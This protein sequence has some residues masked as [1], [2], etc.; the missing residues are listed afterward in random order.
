MPDCKDFQRR[1][2]LFLDGE[3]DGRA[4]RELALHASR[5][6]SCEEE[7]R[8]CEGVQTVLAAAV[9]AELQRVDPAA[10]WTG[11]RGRL[12]PIRPSVAVRVRERAERW[13]RFGADLAPPLW[14]TAAA[15][16]VGVAALLWAWQPATRPVAVANNEA[17]IDR[18]ATSA[19]DVAVW[20]EPEEHT[21]A[22]W[23]AS[24]EP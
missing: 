1:F 5:C 17:R 8:I 2:D 18:L 6:V 3:L 4:M 23:V 13:L 21:T 19:N 24:Y 7:L 20:S 11:I 9:D 22:I 15:L 16:A 14:A 10:L 12:E